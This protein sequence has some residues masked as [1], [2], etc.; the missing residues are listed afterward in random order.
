MLDYSGNLTGEPFLYIETRTI[1]RHLLNGEDKTQLKKRVIDENLINYNKVSSIKRVLPAMFRRLDVMDK[2]MLEAFVN[3]DVETSKYILLYTIM[4]TDRLMRD[5]IAEIYKDKIYMREEYIEKFEVTNWYQE[6]CAISETLSKYNESTAKK[7]RQVITKILQDS[8]LV[9][10]EKDRFKIIRP[11]LSDRYIE[12]L[13][14][15]GDV[16]YAKALGGLV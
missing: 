9:I 2:E 15:N 6:K 13:S 3:S 12:M 8:G 16:V 1:G 11:L 7:L 14:K 4:K 5:F 10:K